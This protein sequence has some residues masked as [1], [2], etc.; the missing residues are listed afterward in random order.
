HP[1][2]PWCRSKVSY[3][4]DETVLHRGCSRGFFCKEPASPP[5]SS[6]SERLCLPLLG[7]LPI[8]SEPH[9]WNRGGAHSESRTA[10]RPAGHPTTHASR[11]YLSPRDEPCPR[12]Q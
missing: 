9:G 1:E 5:A 7:P 2:L 12:S 10:L 11:T 3:P 6:S 8:S 4:D